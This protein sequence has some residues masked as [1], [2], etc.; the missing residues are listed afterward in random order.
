MFSFAEKDNQSGIKFE[1]LAG[2]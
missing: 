2:Y 1:N